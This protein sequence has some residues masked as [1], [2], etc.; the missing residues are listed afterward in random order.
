MSFLVDTNVLSA[1]RKPMRANVGVAGWLASTAPD[2]LYLSV[3]VVGEVRK[4]VDLLARRDPLA[5]T[6]FQEWLTTVRRDYEGRVL[7]ITEEIAERWGRMNAVRPLPVID[8]LM[9]ATAVVHDL[10]LVTRNERDVEGCGARTL[11]PFS[12]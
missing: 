5:A 4:G 2:E 3:L 8:G 1:A 11:N 12:R 7:P 9:A 10:T 6:V